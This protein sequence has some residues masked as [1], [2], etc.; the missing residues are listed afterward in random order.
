MTTMALLLAFTVPVKA[1]AAVPSVNEMCVCYTDDNDYVADFEL[2][3]L[4]E[5]TDGLFTLECKE[6]EL[7]I[8]ANSDVKTYEIDQMTINQ[9]III[10]VKPKEDTEIMEIT[11]DSDNNDVVSVEKEEQKNSIKLRA[12]KAYNNPVNIEVSFKIS[13]EKNVRTKIVIKKVKADNNDGSATTQDGDFTVEITEN[14]RPQSPIWRSLK[15]KSYEI[16][17]MTIGGC[18]VDFKITPTTLNPYITSSDET[19]ISIES[20]ANGVWHITA[21][22]KAQDVK[23]TIKVNEIE[24]SFTIQEINNSEPKDSETKGGGTSSS[25]GTD[26][27]DNKSASDEKIS[28]LQQENKQLSDE[29]DK[30]NE[31]LKRV[32][33][34]NENENEKL[35]KTIEQLKKYN[36]YTAL[37]AFGATLLLSILVF[38]AA[39]KKKRSLEKDLYN[40]NNKITTLEGRLKN[41]QTNNIDKNNSKVKDYENEIIKLKKELED[42]KMEL[43]KLQQQQQTIPPSPAPTPAPVPPVKPEPPLSVVFLYADNII[44]GCLNKVVNTPDIENTIYELVLD[45]ENASTARVRVYDG[46]RPR[47][48]RY[49]TFLEGCEM[50]ILNSS[51]TIVDVVKEGVATKDNNSN[52]VVTTPPMIEIR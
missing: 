31:Q 49:P 18:G 37:I 5:G 10:T 29:K 14:P 4:D 1:K 44:D 42:A 11:P 39:N 40:A 2:V 22:K 7:K 9:V 16:Q 8:T 45:N 35:T 24:K 12:N 21:K 51:G 19:A 28:Q 32:K 30:L 20:K 13:E 3:E 6:L 41:V 48:L 47:I 46:A 15:D 25:G 43:Y 23:V 50:Q 36:V 34:E 26:S 33:N 52:W 38:I 17:S 27:S